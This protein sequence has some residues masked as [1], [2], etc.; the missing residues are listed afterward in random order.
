MEINTDLT[1][2]VKL[3]KL[4]KSEISKGDLDSAKILLVKAKEML[5]ELNRIIDADQN[6]AS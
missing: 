6:V 5:V 1:A 4:A 3:Q 2:I